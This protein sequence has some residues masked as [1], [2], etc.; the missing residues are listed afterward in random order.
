MMDTLKSFL[1]FGLAIA[2][3]VVAVPILVWV[4]LAA[5]G[6]AVLAAITGSIFGAWAIHKAQ[7]EGSE[8]IIDHK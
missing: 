8:V 5:I 2:L 1:R 6:A 3:A 7:K 4:G